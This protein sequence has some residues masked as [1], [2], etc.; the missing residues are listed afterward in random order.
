MKKLF[1]FFFLV[2]CASSNVNYNKNTLLGF[3]NNL[4]FEE[5]RELLVEYAKTTPYPNI[6]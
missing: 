3:N 6:D 4:T 1:F 5:F 2:S